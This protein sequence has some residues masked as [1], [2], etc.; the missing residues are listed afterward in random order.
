LS[1]C[2]TSRRWR[3][4]ELLRTMAA[5]PAC[6][7]G[8][9]MH[10]EKHPTSRSPAMPTARLILC[11]KTNRWAIAM[12][13]ALDKR[14]DVLVETRSLAQCLREL[15]ASPASLV[16]I[17]TTMDNLDSV[18]ALIESQ[19][20]RFDQ[21]RFVALAGDSIAS[22][23]PLLREAGAAAVFTSARQARQLARIALRHLAHAPPDDLPLVEA[24]WDRLPWR[25]F[26]TRASA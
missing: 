2:L 26:A 5:S 9:T 18:V 4:P 22:A 16:A 6:L 15:A 24:I 13:R 1:R 17:E 21:A 11:E 23:E 10:A 25:G 20:R 7:N 12:R 19:S 8:S 14:S 3:R